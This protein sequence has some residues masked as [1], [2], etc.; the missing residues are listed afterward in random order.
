[1]AVT[2]RASAQAF[3]S[4]NTTSIV[5]PASI[6]TV[7]LLLLQAVGGWTPSIPAGW[8]QEY[9]KAGSN[10]GSF[11]AY[12]TA[13][14][15]DA[16][17]NVTV[18]WSGAY[19]NIVNLIAITGGSGLRAPAS[20]LWS[21]SGGTGTPAAQSAATGDMVVYLGGNR[22]DGGPPTLSRGATD[23]SAKDASSVVAG[24]IGHELL[25]AD[26]QISCTFTAPSSGNGYEYSVLLISGGGI[27]PTNVLVSR[28][29]VAV[30]ANDATTNTH[31]SRQS[32]VVLASDVSANVQVSRQSMNVVTN[33]D[34]IQR[35]T[36]RISIQV[37]IPTAPRFRGW[38]LRR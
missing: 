14:V 30:A 34:I 29:S 4:A 16:G 7:D 22:Q 10:I 21:S 26:T 28:E 27:I 37:L 25:A 23:V 31:V 18:S 20:H 11:I 15:G 38:G 1:M 5:I 19:N 9:A 2:Y 32:L 12:K 8:T 13:T 24:V 17:T 3:S 6:Q 33:D 36:S 35:Q